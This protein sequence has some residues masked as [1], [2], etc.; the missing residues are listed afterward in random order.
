M[1]EPSR[2]PQCGARQAIAAAS[3]RLCASCLFAAALAPDVADADADLEGDDPPFEIVTILARGAG[4]ATY[5]ARGFAATEHVALTIVD[6]ADAA[7]TA[8]RIREWKPRLT[9]LRHPAISRLVDAGLAGSGR[10]YLATEYIP[11]PSLDYVLQRGSLSGE[12]RADILGQV[13]DAVA[14]AHAHGL[15]HMRIDASRIKVATIGGV[16]ATLLG[17]AASAILNG[18]TPDAAVD[19]RSLAQLSGMLGLPTIGR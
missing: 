4:A 15:A 3:L 16:R 1:G 17:L 9:A 11:G 5:L 19:V 18:S 13:G 10:A 12:D 14:A 8:A 7:L 6:V 2:C